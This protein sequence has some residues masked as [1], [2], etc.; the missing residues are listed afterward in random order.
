MGCDAVLSILSISSNEINNLF[1]NMSARRQD[2]IYHVTLKSHITSKRQDGK[3]NSS[4]SSNSISRS[5]CS[6]CCKMVH[7]Y[8]LEY[9]MA[10]KR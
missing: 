4:N 2:S 6:C 8:K 9:E 1:N 7:G 10:C 3:N 5:S